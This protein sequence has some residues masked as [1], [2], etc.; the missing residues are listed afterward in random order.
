VGAAAGKLPLHGL[1][2]HAIADPAASESEGGPRL[3]P[4]GNLARPLRGQ[5]EV[6]CFHLKLRG[7]P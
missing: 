5:R 1:K 7:V 2:D 3:P 6:E 4:A